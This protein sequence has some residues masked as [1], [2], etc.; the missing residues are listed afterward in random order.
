M[1]GTQAQNLQDNFNFTTHIIHNLA[2]LRTTSFKAIYPGFRSHLE[3]P[4]QD[5]FPKYIYSILPL[6]CV[7]RKVRQMHGSFFGLK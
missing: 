7:C 6:M 1:A 3:C 2:H 4:Q 5:L